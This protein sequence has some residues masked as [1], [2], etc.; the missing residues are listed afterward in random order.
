MLGFALKTRAH[1]RGEPA[2]FRRR[3]HYYLSSQK[4]LDGPV[5]RSA[6]CSKRRTYGPDFR[7]EVGGL[8]VGLFRANCGPWKW[9]HA[10]PEGSS[11]GEIRTPTTPQTPPSPPPPPL[12][13]PPPGPPPKPRLGRRRNPHLEAGH[14]R[15][16]FHSVAEAWLRKFFCGPGELYPDLGA[17]WMGEARW[18]GQLLGGGRGIELALGILYGPPVCGKGRWAPLGRR[19]PGCPVDHTAFQR[20][21]DLPMASQQPRLTF[22]RARTPSKAFAGSIKAYGAHFAPT[23]LRRNMPRLGR[24]V[25]RRLWTGLQG[26][27]GLPLF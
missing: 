22:R 4:Q 20:W 23:T 3:E 1:G 11:F 12:P 10:I 7:E 14:L 25:R 21:T 17:G 2:A 19:W 15:T 24:S 9:L 27:R 16:R 26:R 6:I 8:L 5:A 13:H 18:F